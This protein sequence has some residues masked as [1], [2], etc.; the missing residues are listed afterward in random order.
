MSRRKDQLSVMDEVDQCIVEIEQRAAAEVIRRLDENYRHVDWSD[1]GHL[2]DG[3][4]V[5]ICLEVFRK[6][7]YQKHFYRTIVGRHG[8]VSGPKIYLVADPDEEWPDVVPWAGVAGHPDW[9]KWLSY[10][11]FDGWTNGEIVE[12]IPLPI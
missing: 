6:G 2:P 8:S 1:L 7:R 11:N 12:P 4:V 5:I 9:P 10:P 3:L